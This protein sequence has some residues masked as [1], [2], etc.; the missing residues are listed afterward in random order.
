MWCDPQNLL[1]FGDGMSSEVGVIIVLDVAM[2]I[3]MRDVLL[4]YRGSFIRTH[5]SCRAFKAGEAL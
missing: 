3:N 2:E 5:I 4:L 1:C